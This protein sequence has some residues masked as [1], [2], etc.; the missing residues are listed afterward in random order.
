MVFGTFV[1]H[2]IIW[3]ILNVIYLTIDDYNL[4]PQHKIRS[5]PDSSLTPTMRWR[6]FRA[7]AFDHVTQM[8]PLQLLS[9]PLLRAVGFTT[10]EATFPSLS[11]WFLEFVF[12]NVIEDA[13]FYWVH[14]LLH[15]SWCY[16]KVHKRHH[17]FI[18]PFSLV[19]EIAHPAEFLFNF[20]LPM[21][22]GP[23][24]VGLYCGH[25]H[26]AT[27]WIWMTFR[28][29]RGTEAHSGYNLPYHP[30][31]LLDPIYGGSVAHEFHHS[32]VGRNSNFGG[33]KF[34]DWVMGTDRATK[35]RQK[36][37]QRSMKKKANESDKS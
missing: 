15:T 11:T 12:F 5:E 21:M 26:I 33:Y 17:E 10:D 20:L 13:G 22:A 34:W 25:V 24:I 35:E 14:R 2:Q 27:F 23:F 31:R 19:S 8:L 18:A 9:Y 1:V 32:V 30:L 6:Y 7:I 4:F 37:A 16:A 28:E 3:F 29:M 36:T